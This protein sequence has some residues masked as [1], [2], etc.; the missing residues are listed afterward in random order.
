MTMQMD[1]RDRSHRTSLKQVLREYKNLSRR[2]RRVVG[3]RFQFR[4]EHALTLTWGD[5]SRPQRKISS[6]KASRAD[7][8]RFSEN[9]HRLVALYPAL[10]EKEWNAANPKLLRNGRRRRH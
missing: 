9:T 1:K 10:E 8:L 6:G 4:R 2:E 5:A 7:D 3:Q